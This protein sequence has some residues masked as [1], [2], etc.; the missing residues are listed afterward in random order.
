MFSVLRPAFL[1]MAALWRL[2]PP[3]YNIQENVLATR[4]DSK[5]LYAVARLPRLLLYPYNLA[6]KYWGR[7]QN[8]RLPGIS[9]NHG[10]ARAGC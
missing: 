3:I 5:I 10:C 4:D 2:M 7:C 9:Q 6:F 8:T 1:G